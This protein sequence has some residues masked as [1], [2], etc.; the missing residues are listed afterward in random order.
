MSKTAAI[1]LAP[2]ETVFSRLLVAIDRILM[3]NP[4]IAIRNGDLPYFGL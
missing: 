3:T 4:R 2:S 1:R